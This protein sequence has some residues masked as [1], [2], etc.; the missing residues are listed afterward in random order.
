MVKNS[1]IYVWAMGIDLV[2]HFGK[3]STT[4][5][6]T[7]IYRTVWSDLMTALGCALRMG[8][9][10]TAMF[11]EASD[12]MKAALLGPVMKIVSPLASGVSLI[13]IFSPSHRVLPG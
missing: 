2:L 11:H 13:H 9:H 10:F 1:N 5:H 6:W 7:D 12:L 8:V 4:D 3:N